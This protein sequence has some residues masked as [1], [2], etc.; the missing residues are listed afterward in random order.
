MVQTEKCD[1]CR[2]LGYSRPFIGTG[3]PRQ[4]VC[5]RCKGT[6]DD[7]EG[8]AEDYDEVRHALDGEA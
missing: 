8:D 7:G 1:A 3:D 4:R 2:G 5:D 6:G